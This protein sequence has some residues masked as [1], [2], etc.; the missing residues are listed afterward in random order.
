MLLEMITVFT[1][2]S[3]FLPLQA[4]PQS[5]EPLRLWYDAPTT[6]Y[7]SGLP[8]GNGHLAAM[9]LGKPGSERIALN[10]NRLWRA[11]RRD[12]KNPVVHP[13]LAAIRALFFQGKTVEASHRANRELGT[14]SEIGVDSYQPLGDL[15][16]EE[17]GS[18]P[19]SD[20]RRELDLATG[21]VR[22]SF[23]RGTV[24][25]RRE[26]F[27]S[28]ADNVLVVR[29]LGDA[30]APRLGRAEDPDCA[31]SAGTQ[32]MTG[33][34]P[35]GIAFHAEIRQTA[36]KDGGRVL[37][38]AAGVGDART[39]E[40]GNATAAAQ[41]S[42]RET[43]EKALAATKGRFEKLLER[44]VR[45]HQRLFGRVTLRLG[46]ADAAS[47]PMEKRLA[48]L[49]SGD[50]DSSLLALYFQYGRYLLMSASAPGGLPANLQGIW[51]EDLK[52]P[53]DCDLHFDINLQMNYWPAEPAN[54]SECA[55][56]LF[57]YVEKL[58]PGGR[59][60]ARNLYNCRGVYFPL[61]SDGWATTVKSQGGWSEWT[62]A[63]AWLA[64]HFWW[65][66]EW[67][68]DRD[69]LRKR[70]YPLFKEV[71]AFYEDYLVEDPRPDSSTKGMLVTVPSQSPEN[72]F[73]GGIDPVSLTIGAS[74]DFQLIRDTL[75]HAIAAAVVL[76]VDEPLRAK[77]R[78]ILDRLPPHQIGRFGQ[79]QEW[80]E[81]HEEAEPGHRHVSHLYALFPS[82][83][84]SPE[85][86]PDLTLAA[87]KSLLR[88]LEHKGGHTG[89]SRSWLVGL[90]ARLGDGD[91]AE[92]H[93]RHLVADFATISLLDLHPPRI[94]QIDGNFGGT[95]GLCEM[96]LQS[97]R[98][99]LRIL[100]ALPKAWPEGE[101]RGVVARGGVDVSICWSGGKAREA[102]LRSK[103]GGQ[104]VLRPPVG[105]RFA[106]AR[107]GRARLG[108]VPV[109]GDRGDVALFLP[110]GRDVALV[111]E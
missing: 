91:A 102:T 58:V 42:A 67:S 84:I 99:V 38:L 25:S 89:W 109:S 104:V 31:L 97:H 28:R 66:W 60:A 8:V 24:R 61:V 14:F 16:I 21:V 101:V 79:L 1:V 52:P 22:V 92:E 2:S 40:G 19:V 55:E 41:K 32:E 100:P 5:V 105:Q 29:L 85:T 69:F 44:H 20:Y 74:M 64:Q 17:A 30:A 39:A 27:V 6:E 111:F 107:Q 77:W 35:E 54:L 47:E 68:G 49:R 95:A 75:E 43:L 26:I 90:F 50:Q 51:N 18:Q 108:L 94:F 96:L 70:A 106:A 86:T 36:E 10:H 46:N 93:L 57:D 37:L 3:A 98:G 62:G 9:V 12:R 110:K 15:W 59:E 76:G 34:F 4:K 7:M 80:L 23:R 65:R 103:N 87:R 83:Q 13:S 78:S 82:D 63:A 72:R 88:R 73:V 53:W 71:A 33:A 48:A 81:D 11:R 45:A 56:P